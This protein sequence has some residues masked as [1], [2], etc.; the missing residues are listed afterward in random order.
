MKIFITG[1]AGFIGS[2]LSEKLIERGH[3]VKGYDIRS[4]H[5]DDVRDYSRLKSAISRF[6]PDGVIHLAAVSRVEDGF[7]NPQKCVEVNVG[8]VANVLEAIRQMSPKNRPWLIF[9]SSREVFGEPK[10]LPVV[11]DSPKNV[12][13]IYGVTK[14]SG[15]WLLKNYAD[16][17][18]IKAWVLRFS[19]VYTG[20][21][22]RQERVIPQFINQAL[23]GAPITINGGQQVFDFA[24]IEDTI[25]GVVRCI[26]KIHSS[27]KL[28]DDF[29]L[30]T[31]RKMSIVNLAKLILALTKSKSKIIFN[32]PRR[33]DVNVFWGNP[34][35]PRAVL[36]WTAKHDLPAGLKK[37]I[38]EFQRR[39]KT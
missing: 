20:I 9:S 6:R 2:N 12:L 10:I 18:G 35:K 16:N 34:A 33:Y 19:N 36:G 23:S 5:K 14:L 22:D 28:F 39:K 38:H 32:E 7:L 25:D 31:G 13:N 30:T 11:E 1:N 29:N 17:Y 21:K 3:R 27:P 15:E 24:Y 26:K 8:G 4:N 37:V